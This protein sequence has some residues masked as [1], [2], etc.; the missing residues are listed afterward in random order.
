MYIFALYL[1][2]YAFMNKKIRQAAIIELIRNHVIANQDILLDM[3]LQKGFAVTQATLS[4][5]MKELK[6]IKTLTADGLYQY[7]L[8]DYVQAL[9]PDTSQLTA[10]G[11][12]GI[13]FSGQL[14]VV[15]TRPGYAMS[16]AAEIDSKAAETIIGTVAGDDTVLLILREGISRQSVLN[17]LS[18][19]IPMEM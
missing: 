4:R 11:F 10:F 6:I 3:L 16:I 7:R 5:D 2:I 13:E 18:Q 9:K 12:V 15:K 19:I 1:Y 17:S 8:S 14:A